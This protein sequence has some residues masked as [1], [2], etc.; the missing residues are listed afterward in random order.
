M[1]LYLKRAI[2]GDKYYKLGLEYEIDFIDYKDDEDF[3]AF[4]K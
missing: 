1:L 2:D 3:K 4:L